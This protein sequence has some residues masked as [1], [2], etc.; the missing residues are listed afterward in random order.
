MSAE[1]GKF[2][3]TM[4]VEIEASSCTVMF[5]V[6]PRKL[7][8]ARCALMFLMSQGVVFWGGFFGINGEGIGLDMVALRTALQRS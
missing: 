4:G 8:E 7:N 5:S 3:E 1:S 6:P 2:E